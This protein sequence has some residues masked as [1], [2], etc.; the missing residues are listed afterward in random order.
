MS[1]RLLIGLSVV[2]ATLIAVLPRPSTAANETHATAVQWPTY[3]NGY[4]G[5]RF[6]SATKITAANVNTLKRVCEANLGDAVRN[7]AARKIR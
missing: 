7:C 5:Q 2:V 1:S 3:N 4:N 6:S